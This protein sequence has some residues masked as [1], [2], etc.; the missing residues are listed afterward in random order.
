MMNSA[1]SSAPSA[2]SH[3]VARCTPRGRTFQPNT[4]RPRNVDSRKKAA[5][6]SIAS[7]A[8]NTSPTKREYADQSIPN[9][10]SCT[11]PVTTPTAM[12]SSIRPAEEPGQ[13]PVVRVAGPVPPGVQ[14]RHEQPEADRHRHE[15]EV[16]DRRGRELGSREVEL[17]EVHVASCS[18]G[19]GEPAPPRLHATSAPDR[20]TQVPANRR[21]PARGRPGS[22]EQLGDPRRALEQVVVAEGVRQPQVAGRA[23]R[24]ARAPLP[25]RPRRGSARPARRR[26]AA[27]ARAIS[28]PSTP[29]TEGKT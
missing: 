5:S 9:W 18:G 21:H 16:V 11:R 27:V 3:A 24:L 22:A 29:V 28:R 8:P 2:T 23:E 10:N 15:E 4:H 17:A 14:H 25:P 13:P 1:D 20:M 26:C 19:A 7:G 6:P 12:L